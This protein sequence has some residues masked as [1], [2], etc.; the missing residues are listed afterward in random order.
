MIIKASQ[1]GFAR[2][3]GHHLLNVE[4][5]EHVEVHSTSGFVS[6]DVLGALDEAE[7]I[8]KGTRCRQYLFSISLS[9][10]KGE[11][12][13]IETYE[14]ALSMIEEKMGLEGQPRI[15]LFHEKN[16]R[17]HGHAVY[18]RITPEMKAINLPF[19][20]N[21]MA[22]I[23]KQIYLAYG[24]DLPPGHQDRK[25]TNPLNYSLA[26]WQQARRLDLDPKQIKATLR[27]CWQSGKTKAQ[28]KQALERKGFYLARGDRR[29]FVA[30]DWRGEVFSLSR[31][32]GQKRKVLEERLGPPKELPSVDETREMID[33]QL[34]ER[35]L[36]LIGQLREQNEQQL[37]SQRA[38]VR[39][40]Q[41]RHQRQREALKAQQKLNQDEESLIRQRRFRRGA[42]GLWDRI[43][44]RWTQ[45][46]E[47]NRFEA[48]AAHKRDQAERDDLVNKQII[49]REEVEN[50]IISLHAV[51]EQDRS[52]M[53]D[54]VFS[55]LPAQRYE[56]LAAIIED[57]RNIRESPSL[58][59]EY[60]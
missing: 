20:K 29:G 16:G 59:Q 48:F 32:T 21:R 19:Y 6:S 60:A 3:L 18:S 1:R 28:V 34:C 52:R 5:N 40:L 37:F 53:I 14:T 30:V 45:I 56:T 27:E 38:K 13:D 58:A 4:D 50:V 26:E 51:F 35:M 7:A 22:A 17:R 15:V 24:W 39:R 31:S 12:A 33:Q 49:E 54:K 47:R 42:L 36:S 10:P 57:V 8:A 41:D 55:A 9:P 25:L 44:G 11:R 2:K 23:S 43:R 46:E